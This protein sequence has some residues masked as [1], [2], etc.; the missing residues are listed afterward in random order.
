M[1]Q[2][3]TVAA[4]IVL[5]A[6]LAV[7][8]AVHAGAT[9]DAPTPPQASAQADVQ[10]DVAPAPEQTD[11]PEELV[12]TSEPP[13]LIYEEQDDMP[14][15]GMYWVPGYWQWSGNDWAW[16]YGG[17]NTPP[18][19]RLYIAPY[20]EHVD[21]HV[22]YVGGYWGAQGEEPRYYGGDRIVFTA[23]IRPDGYVRGQHTFVAR[24]TGIQPGHRASYGAKLAGVKKRALPT[25]TAPRVAVTAGLHAEAH[26]EAHAEAH[27]EGHAEAAH[28][29]AAHTEAHATTEA[30]P[31]AKP[32]SKPA[33]QPQS[34]PAPQ[35][36]PAP[37]PRKK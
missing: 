33:P 10:V 35:P 36:K 4:A 37:R 18:E 17:W 8:C 9:V 31:E 19:G 34:H 3:A 22:V 6:S 2:T 20:Y 30:K 15:P 12:A 13:E 11:D 29:E 32:E 5:G 23:A 1:K 25:A 28:A 27:A 14:T 24:A 7:G 21:D 26:P 16:Y